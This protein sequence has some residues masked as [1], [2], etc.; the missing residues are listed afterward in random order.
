MPIASVNIQ[1]SSTTLD[2]SG[3]SS[4]KNM[5]DLQDVNEIEV[6]SEIES[7]VNSNN[8]N[9]SDTPEQYVYF[10]DKGNS[11][12]IEVETKI[13]EEAP[14]YSNV[15]SISPSSNVPIIVKNA[16]TDHVYCNIDETIAKGNAGSCAGAGNRFMSDSIELDLDDPLLTSSFIKK[17]DHHNV[18]ETSSSTHGTEQTSGKQ[19]PSI[20]SSSSTGT[21]VTSIE[22]KNVLNVVAFQKNNNNATLKQPVSIAPALRQDTMIDTALDLDSLDGIMGNSIQLKAQHIE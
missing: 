9:K 19:I 13:L 12:S 8:N 14:Q 21:Q 6:V 2:K 11:L 10:R 4:L 16:V 18:Y 15:P 1:S 20:S 22:L 17:N 5:T 3:R 7:S